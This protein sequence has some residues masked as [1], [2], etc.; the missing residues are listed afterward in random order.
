MMV[1]YSMFLCIFHNLLF[2]FTFAHIVTVHSY[3][4]T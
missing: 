3:V 2:R 1:L 4:S